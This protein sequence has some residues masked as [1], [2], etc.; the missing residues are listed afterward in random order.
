MCN[1]CSQNLVS[2][3]FLVNPFYTALRVPVGAVFST[4]WDFAANT[5]C[6]FEELLLGATLPY[7]AQ[8]HANV[9]L[10]PL[11]LA[12]LLRQCLN[13]SQQ[14]HV[15][16]MMVPCL[17]CSFALQKIVQRNRLQPPTPARH[18][19]CQRAQGSGFFE[20]KAV[21][22]ELIWSIPMTQNFVV[23]RIRLWQSDWTGPRALATSVLWFISALRSRRQRG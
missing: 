13:I 14:F 22:R 1:T 15:L 2:A 10:D 8:E 17:K 5:W 6:R 4:R 16:V 19:S 21:A 3:G 12:Y 23:Q 11:S 9:I 7:I 18:R 20:T